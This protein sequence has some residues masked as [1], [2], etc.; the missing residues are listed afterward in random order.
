MENQPTIDNR[1]NTEAE[2]AIREA[3][4]AVAP[5]NFHITLNTLSHRGVPKAVIE[6]IFVYRQRCRAGDHD[7]E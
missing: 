3:R 1:A 7:P 6:R 2:L 5:D 4:L